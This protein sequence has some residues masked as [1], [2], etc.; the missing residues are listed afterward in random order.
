MGRLAD[1][2][3]VIT[4]STGGMG[5]GIARLFADEGARVVIS[6]RG[7]EKGAAVVAAIKEAGGEAV[8][9]RVQ[10]MM[11][12]RPTRQLHCALQTLE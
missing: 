2:V 9:H 12:L 4:G 5:E 11:T 7:A 6:G 10:L 8:F 3:A 1:R